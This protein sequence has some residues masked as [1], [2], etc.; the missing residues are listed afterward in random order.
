MESR[1]NSLCGLNVN[2]KQSREQMKTLREQ[3]I[4]DMKSIGR[5][6]ITTEN[7]MTVKL[8][9]KKSRKA[10]GAKAMF[11][12][13]QSQLGEEAAGKVRAA[14]ELARGQPKITHTLKISETEAAPETSL[15]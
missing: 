3:L 14:C 12:V 13:I 1:A 8:I 9:E 15:V 6:S 11:T 5:T 7:N 2:A 10:I 4:E